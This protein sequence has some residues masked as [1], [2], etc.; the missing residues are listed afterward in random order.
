VSNIHVQ[1]LSGPI[2]RD[3]FGICPHS[4]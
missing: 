2:G 3:R 4:G 1:Q